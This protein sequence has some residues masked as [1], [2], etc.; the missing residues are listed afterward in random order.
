MPELTIIE[1]IRLALCDELAH[2]KLE[3]EH[4]SEDNMNWISLRVFFHRDNG[5]PISTVFQMEVRRD[6]NKRG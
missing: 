5:S 2:R 3:I 6:L 1:R 4:A